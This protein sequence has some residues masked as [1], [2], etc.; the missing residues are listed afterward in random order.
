MTISVA[1][2]QIMGWRGA[3]KVFS[4]NLKSCE[5]EINI[6]SDTQAIFESLCDQI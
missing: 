6:S 5:E 4:S 3:K 2:S 1:I